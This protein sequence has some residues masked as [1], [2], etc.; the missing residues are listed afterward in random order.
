MMA[1]RNCRHN[2]YSSSTNSLCTRTA[3]LRDLIG[4]PRTSRWARVN[5]APKSRISAEDAAFRRPRRDIPDRV[6]RLLHLGEYGGRADHDGGNPY[7]GR[8][9]AADLDLGI[10]HR[11][12]D[13][14]GGLRTD[15]PLQ[16]LHELTFGG[17]FSQHQPDDRHR[18]DH[19]RSYRKHGKES[20][21]GGI[22]ERVAL[23]PIASGR[24]EDS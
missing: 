3:V 22:D 7:Q 20:Q 10:R 18:H 21:H 23:Q 6:E 19:Y 12:L 8:P 5:A 15:R 11:G 17:L 24:E 4:R 13:R 2:N 9:D 16:L 1:A 14:L